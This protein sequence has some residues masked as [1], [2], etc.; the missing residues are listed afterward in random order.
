SAARVD[1]HVHLVPEVRTASAFAMR[2]LRIGIE[3]RALAQ[4]LSAAPSCGL[5]HRRL[6]QRRV[7]QSATLDEQAARLQLPIHF[8]EQLRAQASAQL[9][10]EAADSGII[11]DFLLQT[12][13]YEAPKTQPVGQRFLQLRVR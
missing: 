11:G 3:R 4:I 2:P 13:T 6:D 5:A 7:D 9:L 8:A 12:K 1:R 10:A